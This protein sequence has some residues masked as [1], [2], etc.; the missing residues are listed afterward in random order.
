MWTWIRGLLMGALLAAAWGSCPAVA[1]DLVLTGRG[2][3]TY[4]KNKEAM[5]A[6][7]DA[8]GAALAAAVDKALT[9]FVTPEVRQ[10]HAA[11]IE[12]E[13]LPTAAA[14][15]ESH[16]IVSEADRDKTYEVVLKAWIDEEG[17]R[18]NLDALRISQDVG[19]RRAIAVLIQEY[20]QADLRPTDEERVSEVVDT[21]R[22]DHET[23]RT[24]DSQSHSNS[25]S[26]LSGPGMPS[27]VHHAV[28]GSTSHEVHSDTTTDLHE[29][30][31]RFFPPSALRTPRTDPVSGAGIASH[32]LERDARLIDASVLNKV[33][34]N[35]LGADGVLMSAVDSR[36]LSTKALE[37]GSTY[38][39]DAMLVGV[40]AITRDDTQEHE[41]IFQA[42]AT[43]AVR[44]VDASTGDIL[45]SEVTTQRGRGGSFTEA[46]DAAAGRLGDLLGKELAQ[47]LFAYW[48]KR[49]EKGYEIT[50][51]LHVPGI[52][53]HQKL[54]M[55]DAL[56]AIRSVEHL[57][58]RLYD[59]ANGIVEYTLTTHED[60]LL[61]KKE[62]TRTLLMFPALSGLT[63]EMSL[64]TNWNFTLP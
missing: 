51:R 3:A 30:I 24:V 55:L 12:A 52:D 1:G 43:L 25:G 42:S 19:Q 32:L 50:V 34:D 22:T 14:L 16:T 26:N 60:P 57:E 62:L 64:G 28:S 36:V 18:Q 2:T 27:T 11:V 40:T 48:K 46:A 21:H 44:V 53:T 37:L 13:L 20:A 49:D 31:T 4:K 10:E 45:A 39:F 35:L 29:T 9:R 38:G 54:T 5:A 7:D 6:R 61:V 56:Q 41:G 58:E 17:L 8:I 15:V 33:R 63:E 59:S 23:A 47:D